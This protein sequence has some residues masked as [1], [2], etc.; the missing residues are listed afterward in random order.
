MKLILGVLITGL[1]VVTMAFGQQYQPSPFPQATN[2][3]IAGEDL[4]SQTVARQATANS[5][6]LAAKALYATSPAEPE[7]WNDLLPGSMA[8][9]AGW[10]AAEHN[11]FNET[12]AVEA[13]ANRLAMEA[14]KF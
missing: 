5:L 11:I 1:L 3:A 14:N 8:S 12:V 4:F 10:L 6:V 13:N 7:N 9:N 2:S